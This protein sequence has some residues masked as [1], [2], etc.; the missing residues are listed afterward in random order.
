[1]PDREEVLEQEAVRTETTDNPELNRFEIRVGDDLAGFAAYRRR[2]DRLI[3]T[4]TEVG[5]AYSGQGVGS[6]LAEDALTTV[7]KRKEKLVALCPFISSYLEQN[8]E[9]G[10]L[11]DAELTAAMRR[12]SQTSR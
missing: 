11:V 9:F 8:P 5:D 1:M 10:D 4:H 7:R 6:R 12:G 3:F 2:G